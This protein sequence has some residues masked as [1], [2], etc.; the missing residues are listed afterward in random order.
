VTQASSGTTDMTRNVREVTTVAGE[1]GAAA[2]EVL[3]AASELS[4]QAE[5]LNVE[6]QSFVEAMNRVA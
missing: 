5:N 1:S 6:M 4:K 3:G 2:A